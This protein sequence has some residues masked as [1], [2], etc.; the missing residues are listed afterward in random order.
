ME[1]INF[2]I[3][4]SGT[5]IFGLLEDW[6]AGMPLTERDIARFI[7]KLNQAGD[8]KS[9]SALPDCGPHVCLVSSGSDYPVT[10]SRLHNG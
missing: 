7:S 1:S 3:I 2:S 4:P 10:S 9:S 6:Q 8:G 5:F